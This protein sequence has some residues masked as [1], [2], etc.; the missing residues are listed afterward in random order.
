MLICPYRNKCDRTKYCFHVEPHFE[1]ANCTVRICQNI[2][3][4]DI[5]CQEEIVVYTKEV[6]KESDK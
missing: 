5:V 4:M 1:R 6:L 3:H 2:E